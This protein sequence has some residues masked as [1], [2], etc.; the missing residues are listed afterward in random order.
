MQWK[1]WIPWTMVV[2]RAVLGPVVVI[3]ERCGWSGVALGLLVVSALFSDILDGVLARRWRIDTAALRVSDTLADTLFYLCVAVAICVGV[4]AVRLH[5]RTGLLIVAACEGLHFG[6]DLMKFRKPASYHSYLAKTWGLV[7][8]TAIV[9]TFTTQRVSLWI[10]AAI[11]LG[12]LSNGETLAMSL[13]LPRWQCDV[14]SLAMAWR[15]RRKMLSEGRQRWPRAGVVAGLVAFLCVVHG[16]GCV[17]AQSLQHVTYLGGTA[18]P[19]S[20]MHGR[21]SIGATDALAFEGAT[22]LTVPYDH[23]ISYESSRHKKVP[24]GLLTEGIWRLIAPWPETK[25]L[26]LTYRDGSDRTQVVVL[27]MPVADEALLVEVLKARVPRTAQ[28]FVPGLRPPVIMQ[29]RTER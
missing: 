14:K 13:L 19:A 5:C 8:A 29:G 3:G 24:V 23:V 7:L 2:G 1:R 10:D 6:F 16:T 11:C 26:S 21:L 17:Q 27:E 20:G 22:K 18:L 4:P 28:P 12:V 25:Q 15:I 9:V